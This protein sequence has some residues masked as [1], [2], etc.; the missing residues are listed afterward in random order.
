MRTTRR[1]FTS[2]G[3]LG[4]LITVAMNL[5]SLVLFR[6]PAAEFLSH[7]WWLSWFPSYLLWTTFLFISLGFVFADHRHG[8]SPEQDN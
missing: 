3:V 5:L 8:G 4:L 6:R 2:I 1:I 7:G